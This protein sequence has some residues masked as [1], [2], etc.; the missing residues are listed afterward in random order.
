MVGEPSAHPIK[1]LGHT[2]NEGFVGVLGEAEGGEPLIQLSGGFAQLTPRLGQE[3]KIIHVAHIVHALLRKIG[4]HLGEME[5]PHQGAKG[6]PAGNAF[7][8][9]VKYAAQIDGVMHVLGE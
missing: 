3:H 2:A 4:I 6:T 5:G 7:F 1:P 8:R 9:G